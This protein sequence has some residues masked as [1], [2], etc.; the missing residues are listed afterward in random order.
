MATCG[1]IKSRDYLFCI[2]PTYQQ[3]DPTPPPPPQ[4]KHKSIL[5]PNSNMEMGMA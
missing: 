1:Y 2:T 5:S 3:P 4:H